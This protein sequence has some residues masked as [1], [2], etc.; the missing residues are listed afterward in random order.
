MAGAQGYN[1]YN[2]VQGLERPTGFNNHLAGTDKCGV[3]QTLYVTP[4]RTYGIELHY[5]FC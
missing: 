4:P 2:Y 3:Y 1:R 5:K